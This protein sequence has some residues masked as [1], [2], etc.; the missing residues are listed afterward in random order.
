MVTTP[1]RLKDLPGVPTSRELGWPEMEKITGW[2]A[3]IGPPG[4]PKEVTERWAEV[5]RKLALDADWLAGNVKLAGIPAIR[6][7]A[8][9][10]QFMREQY[11]LYEKIAISL[12][13]RQ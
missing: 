1:E 11:E 8:E 3:L 5:M 10:E 2:T 9:T 6:S 7:P 12:G 13:V 4:L